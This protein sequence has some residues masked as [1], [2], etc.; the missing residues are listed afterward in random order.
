MK[1][2]LFFVSSMQGGG[3]ERVA[4]LLCNYWAGSGHAVTLVPTYSG[5][6]ECLYPLD[7]PVRL[8][9]LADRVGS[10]RKSPVTL[11]RRFWAM[12]GLV[13][14][15]QPDAVVSFLSHVNVA[16]LL[17]ARGLDVPVVVSERTYPPVMSIGPVW[18]RLRRRVYPWA[19]TVVMQTQRGCEWLLREVPGARVTVIPN[20]CSYPLPVAK[21]KVA[22]SEW[23]SSDRRVLLAVGR[24]GEEKGFA[25]LIEAFAPLA[26]RFPEWDLVIV[27]EGDERSILEAMI[28][29]LGLRGR[30][31]LP[32]RAGNLA[33]WYLRAELYV[34]SSRFEGFPNTLLEAMAH[35]VPAVSFDCDTGPAEIIRDGVDGRLVDPE[36]GPDG[37]G[38]ALADMMGDDSERARMAGEAVSA[39]D[40]FS[41]ARIGAMW[42]EVLGL[43]A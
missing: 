30:V 38:S 3:A 10:T 18:P 4:A 37:L 32:G 19:S 39:R 2:L 8:K 21:P 24:L 33:E 35:G 13:R 20:P 7:E 22:P 25:G 9:Y 31:V 12:R 17:A 27:G 16:A 41:L 29:E 34:V 42:D 15:L 26:A 28:Q 36:S 40:R 6:G 43:T 14:E 1:R 5:R 11:L 23:I